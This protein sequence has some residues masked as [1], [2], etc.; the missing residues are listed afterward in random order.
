M[1]TTNHS[2]NDLVARKR[3]REQRSRVRIRV[4]SSGWKSN[5]LNA[6]CLTGS[7][8]LCLAHFE[9]LQ[10]DADYKLLEF[11][12]FSA[13]ALQILPH[14]VLNGHWLSTALFFLHLIGIKLSKTR[15]TFPSLLA[16]FAWPINAFLHFEQN[17]HHDYLISRLAL[18][19]F[20][21]IIST[22]ILFLP[23]KL[24]RTK[25]ENTFYSAFSIASTPTSQQSSQLNLSQ[26]SLSNRTIDFDNDT[27]SLFSSHTAGLIKRK[28]QQGTQNNDNGMNKHDHGNVFLATPS[29]FGGQR[30]GNFDTMSLRSGKTFASAGSTTS[31][32]FS[33][34]GQQSNKSS[35]SWREKRRESTPLREVRELIDDLLINTTD[36]DNDD[37]NDEG[38]S[39]GRIAPMHQK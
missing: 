25:K 17:N 7:L 36:E 39:L 31:P 1:P 12:T 15:F 20:T 37:S 27:G 13:N 8:L 2:L 35:T 38:S 26:C 18:S 4:I 23:K 28:K 22:A 32:S 9:H 11:G 21:V 19:A 10:S 29:M 30:S 24:K 34:F 3:R 16:V 14:I 5:V 33:A 6:A